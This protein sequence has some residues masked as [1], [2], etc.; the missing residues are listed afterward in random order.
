[1]MIEIRL[2]DH[3]VTDNKSFITQSFI[4]I[5]TFLFFKFFN[6]EWQMMLGLQFSV[7]DIIGAL[8]GDT[9][10]EWQIM[11]CLQLVL[12]TTIYLMTLNTIPSVVP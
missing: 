5:F 11:S 6:K 7:G 9:T 12:S 3:L 10:H 2:K 4:F 8:L 1:M